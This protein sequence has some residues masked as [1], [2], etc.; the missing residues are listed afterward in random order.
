MCTVRRRARLPGRLAVLVGALVWLAAPA[1]VSAATRYD[2]HL[3]FRTYRTAHFDIHAHQREEGLAQRLTAIAERVRSTFEPTLG[4]PRG[5]VQVILVDQTDVANGWATPFPYDAIEVTAVPPID[6]QLIGN[7]T[8]WLEVVFTHEYTHILHL[9]RSRGFMQ[10]VRRVFG[11]APLVFPNTFLPE[12]QIEGLATYQESRMTGEGRIPAGDFRAIVDTAARQRQF[13]PIDRAGGGLDDWPVGNAP[14][15]FGA[16]FHQYLSDR[17]G[18]ERLDALADATA[19]RLPFFGA[20]AFQTVF[21]SSVG[22]LWE[23][24]RASRERAAAPAGTTDG[25][26]RRLTHHGFTV[27]APA[28]G[29]DGVI[30]YRSTNADAFSTLMRLDGD[31]PTRLAWRVLGDRT[32]VRGD[33]VVFDQVQRV[34]SVATYTDLYAVA[35]T[36]GRVVRLTKNARAQH[37]DLSPDG[38]RIA[39]VVQ[40]TGRRA[41]ALLDFHPGGPAAAPRVIVDDPSADF[42]GPRWSPDG[43]TLVVARRRPGVYDLV[44]VDP[45]TGVVRPLVARADARLVTPSWSP[46]G[47]TVLFAADLGDAPFNIYAVDVQT[48]AVRTV[49]DTASGAQFPEIAPDGS[50]LYL[51]YTAEGYDLF[52]VPAGAFRL[53]AEATEWEET[54]EFRLKAETTGS[55]GIGAQAYNPWKTLVPRYWEPLIE[56]DSGETL[57][58]A[59]TTM[60][61]ALGRHTYGANAAWSTSRGRPD[62]GVSYAYDRWRPTLFAT[63]SDDTD[64][65]A[66]GEVR[67]REAFAGALMVFR[68]IR[69]SQ[70]WLGGFDAET[71]T[72]TCTTAC[73]RIGRRDL[74]SLR[75]GWLFDSRRQFPY[76]ISTE[77]GLAV[78]VSGDANRAAFG[79][80]GNA[81]AGIVDVRGFH[82]IFG[83]HAVVAVR[84]AGAGATRLRGACSQ[85]RVRVP[86]CPP[87]TSAGTRSDCS[88]ASP[89]TPSSAHT[90]RCSTPICGCRCCAS[91]AASGRGRSSCARSTRR[92]SSMPATPGARRFAP[93]TSAA[94]WAARSRRISSC[95]TSSA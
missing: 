42:T 53:K 28:V 43:T 81:G 29:S 27:A 84:L 55:E 80:D 44:L 88:A 54:G 41:L 45:A 9:D 67:S 25:S 5:R 21:G 79:S 12:W 3:R 94:R 90:R 48:G 2:P 68:R 16:Y 49:T 50:L 62:W 82:R 46:D 15:A 24:F 93:P 77:E 69:W 51:G 1:S 85:R 73:R 76:S 17:F 89:P 47:G 63:Y 95:Y 19:G 14:Y 34:R 38:R 91:S 39:C 61:D 65:A 8:D 40:M 59:A 18:P 83:K 32:S 87:S 75:A 86:R 30:Y 31:T 26:A 74:R 78:E 72:A 20:G 10:G 36:G 70:S 64:P 4:V 56:S 35:R 58:G 6:E 60:S 7:T 66:G 33:W 13:A 71:D 11:R 37:P 23:E 92:R 57:V 22:T 52:S